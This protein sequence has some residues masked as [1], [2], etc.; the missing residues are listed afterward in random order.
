MNTILA[1]AARSA[2]SF[3]VALAFSAEV[4]AAHVGHDPAPVVAVASEAPARIVADAPLAGPL[5]RGVVIIP[6]RTE[7]L[8][9]VPV[10]GTAPSDAVSRVG[11]LHISLDGASWV[12]AHT[13]GDPLIIQGLS[14]G[15]H[16]VLI[17]LADPAHKIIDSQTVSF[18]IPQAGSGR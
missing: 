4:R 14:P 13:S 15:P 1:Y 11:H 6:F 2:L 5:A 10:F 8:R 18:E 12:W 16:R 17:E 7:N 3:A 9:I